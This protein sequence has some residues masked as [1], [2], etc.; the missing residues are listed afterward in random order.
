MYMLHAFTLT[1]FIKIL[2][3]FY[4]LKYFK[5]CVCECAWMH[6]YVYVGDHGDEK[7]QIPQ[8]QG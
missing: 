5:K 4:T 7:K 2:F 1:I 8:N 3:H 6:S